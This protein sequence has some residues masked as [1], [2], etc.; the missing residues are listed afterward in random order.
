M[1]D[2]LLTR[3]WELAQGQRWFAGASRGARPVAAELGDDVGAGIRSATFTVE[4]PNASS[5]RY[6]VP[7]APG[8]P[9]RDLCD[10]PAAAGQLLELLAN[11]AAGFERVRDDVPTGLPGRR[12]AGEQSNTSL[13][14][15]GQVMGKVFRR[16]EEGPSVEVELVRALAGT[17]ATAELYGV[18]RDAR[19]D[20]AIF[21]EALTDPT[22]GYVAACD[23][24]AAGRD[25]SGH[26]R[27]LGS[28]LR[29]VHQTLAERL[30][31]A[32]G[33]GSALA[34]NFTTRLDAAVTEAV[35]LA[36]LRD[37]VA[38]QYGGLE[39]VSF[40]VQRIHGDCH[41]GQTLLS[42]DVWKYVDFEGEPLKTL[43]ERRQPDSVWRD[44]AGMLRSFDYAAATAPGSGAWRDD[45]RGA[46]LDGYG[47]PSTQEQTLL[48]AFEV[49]KAVYEVIYESRNRPHLL[50]VPL[51]ALRTLTA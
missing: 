9:V 43:E 1:S 17:G 28:T 31:T 8:E 38:A 36:P 5:E 37:A 25:F 33:D 24:V 50:E 29:L 46:F 41:L 39:D 18:W 51:G 21:V 48:D 44:V 7:L 2:D 32:V 12:Y 20:L 22:D 6:H 27:A 45:A 3:L 15:G 10:D 13:F 4:Y 35:E 26:A 49:D 40:P 11:G 16:L 30:P 42:E 34:A 47:A 14:Y 23:A 19:T